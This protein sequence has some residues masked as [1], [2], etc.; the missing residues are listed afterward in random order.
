MNRTAVLLLLNSVL[1]IVANGESLCKVGTDCASG[2]SCA[3][4]YGPGTC[5]NK[6]TVNQELKKCEPCGAGTKGKCD[7]FGCNSAM[8]VCNT[9]LA[10]ATNLGAAKCASK[11]VNFCQIAADC[12]TLRCQCSKLKSIPVGTCAESTKYRN[13]AKDCPTCSSDASCGTGKCQSQADPVLGRKICVDCAATHQET[14]FAACLGVSSKTSA[15]PVKSGSSK[16]SSSPVPCVSTAW[17]RDNGVADAAIR[18]SGA[19]RVLCISGLPC[20]TPGHLLRNSNSKLVS[21]REICEH[22]A[23][24]VES[25]MPVSQLSHAFDWSQFTDS[26]GLLSLTSLS[27]HSHSTPLSPSRIIAHLTDRMNKVGLGSLSNAV[28]LFPHN[29]FNSNAFRCVVSSS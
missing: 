23:D 25:V 2:C 26:E 14:A 8:K 20:G 19:A 1:L 4:D 7:P 29:V 9:C 28:A 16:P 5:I 22:R 12:G 15:K 18:H 27:A 3:A 6:A 21:Y 11:H 10:R 13:A 17:L 24:C